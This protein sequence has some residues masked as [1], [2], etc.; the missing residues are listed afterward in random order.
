MHRNEPFVGEYFYKHRDSSLAL[1]WIIIRT[2]TYAGRTCKVALTEQSR[3]AK[4]EYIMS[5]FHRLSK[6]KR[7]G[8]V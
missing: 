4:L 6:K 7:R 2:R 3:I 8:V 1:S 5:N